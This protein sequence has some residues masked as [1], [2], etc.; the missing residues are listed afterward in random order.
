VNDDHVIESVTSTS[1]S[2]EIQPHEN[3][4]TSSKAELPQSNMAIDTD[5]EQRLKVMSEDR[6]ALRV[7]MSQL[8]QQLELLQT[9]HDEEL[10]SL[11]NDLEE[12]E[13]AKDQAIDQF[14]TLR[15]R[16]GGIKATLGDRMKVKDAAL[17]DANERNEQL[18]SQLD[19]LKETNEALQ[20]EL[21]RLSEEATE[22][23]AELSSLRNR[24]TLSQQNFNSER[25]DLLEQNAHLRQEVDAAKDAMGEWEVLAM[26]ERSIRENL[27]ERVAELEDEL[28][29]HK[30]LSDRAESERDIQLHAVEGLQRALHEVQEARRIELRETV[31]RTDTQ[32]EALNK[33]VQQAEARATQA[34]SSNRGLESALE[35]AAP[36]EKEVKEKNLLIGKLRHEA[37][38]LNDHLTKALRFLKKARPEENID[39][40]A[41]LHEFCLK[42]S[43]Y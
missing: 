34:E 7:E 2:N 10:A 23:A 14:E 22:N 21:S 3:G 25:D 40:S 33:L 16:I 24:N 42:I 41:L 18:E 8:R 28:S 5:T 30:E 1:D 19:S 31:E 29:R 32:L 13:S 15:G 4:E 6:E 11:R 17:D 43:P 20:R 36:F 38:V 39:R 26:E 9:K 35:R 12:S 27:A 37:I